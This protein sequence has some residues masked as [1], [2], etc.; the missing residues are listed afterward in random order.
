M[1]VLSRKTGQRIHI[2]S[3]ITVSLLEVSGKSVRIGIEA[4]DAVLILRGEVKEQIERENRMAASH[5]K[6]LDE[7]KKISPLSGLLSLK[8]R[9]NEH[10]EEE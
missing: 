1:L 6:H 4:P 7:L 8:T 5:V 10:A 2:G 9:E 3:D